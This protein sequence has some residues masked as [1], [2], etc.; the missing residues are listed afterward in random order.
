MDRGGRAQHAIVVAVGHVSRKHH[1]K[2]ELIAGYPSRDYLAG[3]IRVAVAAVEGAVCASVLAFEAVA[4]LPEAERDL[5]H[6]IAPAAG[7][8]ARRSDTRRSRP[9]PG[10]VSRLR[11][12]GAGIQVSGQGDSKNY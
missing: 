3:V 4:L 7:K 12:A 2:T 5:V 9:I 8:T 6:R 1:R 11:E 10:H